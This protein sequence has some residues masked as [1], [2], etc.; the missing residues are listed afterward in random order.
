MNLPLCV[1]PRKWLH[2]QHTYVLR[3]V[4]G[5]SVG[6]GSRWVMSGGSDLDVLSQ[7]LFTV[8]LLSSCSCHSFCPCHPQERW[9]TLT[10]PTP[11]SDGLLEKEKQKTKLSVLAARIFEYNCLPS[12]AFFYW[13]PPTAI[14]SLSSV[15]NSWR[16]PSAKFFLCSIILQLHSCAFSL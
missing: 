4:S 3:C 5:A 2:M 7:P 1:S 10:T 6:K 14:Y 11:N 12:A 9:D 8:R 15:L 16:M 13:I